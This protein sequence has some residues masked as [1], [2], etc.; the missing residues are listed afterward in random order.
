[1]GTCVRTGGALAGASAAGPRDTPPGHGG[2]VS[3]THPPIRPSA[4]SRSPHLL[5][6]LASTG[7]HRRAPEEVAVA[8]TAVRRSPPPAGPSVTLRLVA[9][10]GRPG[11]RP[12]RA[13][14]HGTVDRGPRLVTTAD[15]RRPPS[16]RP[17]RPGR[18]TGQHRA[19]SATSARWA[20]PVLTG[21]ATVAA[22]VVAGLLWGGGTVVPDQPVGPAV[23]VHVVEP[24]DTL[25]SVARAVRPEA[26]VRAT[27]DDLVQ[28]RG[29]ADLR[30]G[31]V[32]HLPRG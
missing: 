15:R 30:P 28:D 21:A 8:T 7:A 3:R 20:R 16:Q 29:G 10:D 24:G 26:P 11:P 25:W 18:V 14:G 2:A 22:G 19:A 27:V 5:D 23:A 17:S 12:H 32:L 6:D 13:V 9:S 4:G 31:D 1:M